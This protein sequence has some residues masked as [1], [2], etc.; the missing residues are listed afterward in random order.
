M[1]GQVVLIEGREPQREIGEYKHL[2]DFCRE[3]NYFSH[4]DYLTM[5]QRVTKGKIVLFLAYDKD[6]LIGALPAIMK[7]GKYGRVINSLPFYGSNPG[8]IVSSGEH[9]GVKNFLMNMF[10]YVTEPFLSATLIESPM[11]RNRG[12]YDNYPPTFIDSRVSLYN[13]FPND[14]SELMNGYHPKTRNLVRKAEK[15]GVIVTLEKKYKKA[16]K[17]IEDIHVENMQSIGALPKPG[18]FFDWLENDCNFFNIRVYT[19]KLNK[20]IIAGLILFVHN[21]IAEYYMPAIK[22]EW[23]HVAPLNLIIHRAMI[24]CMVHH[25]KYW[26]WGG[27]TLPSQAGVYHFKKRF[28]AQESIYRYFI[29]VQGDVVKYSREQLAEEYPHFY[30]VPYCA[31]EGGS[32]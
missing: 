28:G 19:A 4:W 15:A 14:P 25:V 11:E 26:N 29:R 23:R 2:V 21:D 5:I 18:V 32:A 17:Q 20:E 31:L 12:I 27:T 22:A 3:A 1:T 30:V 6:E 24:D 16:I 9:I 8:L 7:E 13:V 10:W